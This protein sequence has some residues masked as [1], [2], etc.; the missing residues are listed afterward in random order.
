MMRAERHPTV[1]RAERHPTV[2]RAERRLAP[3][4]DKQA[5]QWSLCSALISQRLQSRQWK[6]I[7][8]AKPSVERAAQILAGEGEGVAG[9]AP[10]ASFDPQ[11]SAPPPPPPPPRTNRTRRVLH[12][13]LIGHAASL[14]AQV[15]TRLLG[16]S[17]T[18][19][20]F[21]SAVPPRP[22]PGSPPPTIIAHHLL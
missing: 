6:D 22:V 20:A 15:E 21:D 2:M 5:A 8:L 4:Q 13:V 14:T 1:M 18:Q 9:A 19:K 3:R 10:R 12:P 16:A 17:L 11:V 7:V